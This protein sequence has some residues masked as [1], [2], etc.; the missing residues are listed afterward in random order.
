MPF[1]P[2]SFPFRSRRRQGRDGQQC[3]RMSPPP[4]PTREFGCAGARSNG[5]TGG[6][7]CPP[8]LDGTDKAE[9]KAEAE[10]WS[11]RRP[12]RLRHRQGSPA[13]AAASP[14]RP[15]PPP[16]LARIASCCCCL[17]TA[18]P[19]ASVTGKD[20]QLLLL[21]L[22]RVPLRLRPPAAAAAS[23]PRPPL[24]PPLARPWGRLETL[25]AVVDRGEATSSET[26]IDRGEVVGGGG[27]VEG[28]DDVGGLAGHLAV[29]EEDGELLMV[30]MEIGQRGRAPL[31]QRRRRRT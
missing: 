8:P 29:W 9:A 15:P 13:A 10:A 27:E 16:S 17:S 3:R 20:R 26:V 23:P 28:G 22:H 4:L 12:R 6:C 5:T 21:P 7:P 2:P 24:P 11:S 1:H 14:P 25:A 30:D 31:P 19:S 18:S